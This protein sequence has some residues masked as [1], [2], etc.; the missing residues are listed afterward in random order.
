MSAVESVKAILQRGAA[1][2]DVAVRGWLRSARHSKGLTFLDLTDGSCFSGIQVVVDGDLPNYANEVASLATGAAVSVVGEL[3]DSPAKGQA[4]EIHAREVEVVG[5]ADP[6]Y[7][8]QKK[9]HSFEYLRTIAHL[10]LRTNT[11]GAILR[12]RNAAS[13][14]VREF[15]DARGFIE[16]HPPVITTQDCEGAGEQFRVSTLDPAAAMGKPVDYSG[17]FFGKA[18]Y[19]T[20][21]G[22][23]EAEIAALALSNVYTFAPTF[24]AEDSNTSR[25]LAEFWM[26]EPEMA[27]CALEGDMDL[28]EAF[29]KHVFASVMNACPDDMEFFNQR[30]DKTVLESLQHVIDSPFERISYS[31]A[32]EI[33]ERADLDFEF[34]VK[35]GLNLQSE[36][37]RYLTEKHIGR[38][39][40]VT[41]YPTDIKPFYMYVND[42]PR[43][44]RAMDVLVPRIGEIVGG[45][46]RED[47]LDVLKQRI[48]AC[49]L[50]EEDYW[51]YL[52]LRRY[53]SVPHS[54]FGVGFE[55]VVQFMTG[56][57]N[58]RD[59]IP[60]P[61][62]PGYAEF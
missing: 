4:F 24:R 58:I 62:V 30:I 15:F 32:V 7:P 48:G 21:S 54:G 43:T 41:D 57:A 6:D 23:L 3:V 31:E 20:V 14:A 26:I 56:M 45:S 55:R 37:E 17:D 53:G 10:R 12:V 8:L 28:A 27:F 5:S 1:G 60:F 19:L 47:R 22:Q 40:I 11:F 38:P 51:W 9:R 39:V 13:M 50:R 49:G 2:G 18:A 46:Q 34:P 29:L 36:H 35:W 16:L 44:V 42:D 59:V 61:R 52:D 33:L 25:H